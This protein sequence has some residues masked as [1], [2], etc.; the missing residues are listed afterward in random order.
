MWVLGIE[1]KSCGRAPLIV[2]SEPSLQPRKDLKKKKKRADISICPI[3]TE[4]GSICPKLGRITHY[5]HT[6]SLWD[7]PHNIKWP[8][9]NLPTV[10]LTCCLYEFFERQGA[11]PDTRALRIIPCGGGLSPRSCVQWWS[12]L[13]QTQQEVVPR[14]SVK[15]TVRKWLQDVFTVHC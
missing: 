5:F 11:V 8:H 4:N 10:R 13:V 9:V 7:P 2:T 14:Q 1:P 15:S 12:A 3:S 6:T